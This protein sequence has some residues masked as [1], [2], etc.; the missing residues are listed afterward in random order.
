VE[1][2]L[3]HV[4]VAVPELAAAEA[5]ERRGLRAV[6]GG[7]HLTLGT[8]NVLVPLG[9]AYVEVVAVA[10]P[11]R[12]GGGWRDWIGPTTPCAR[13]S[14]SGKD[15]TSAPPFLPA[16]HPAG[17]VTLDRVEIGDPSRMLGTWL[18]HIDHVVVGAS[19]QPGVQRVV[20]RVDDRELRLAAD[21]FTLP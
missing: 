4:I 1:L 13:W 15:V 9:G 18:P 8:E 16:D 10:D 19:G 17:R 14:S 11:G 12:C 7:R 6:P 5:L 2:A 21:A 3:D 20:L